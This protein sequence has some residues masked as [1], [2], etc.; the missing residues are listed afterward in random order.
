MTQYYTGYIADNLRYKSRYN[1]MQ[2]HI[3]FVFLFIINPLISIALLAIH[4][5]HQKTKPENLFYLLYILISLYL[6]LIST[7]KVAVSDFINYK[8]Y[9]DSASSLNFFEYMNRFRQEYFFYAA[10]YA[11]NKV[12]FGNFNLYV[13]LVVFVQ[14][15]LIFAAIH[16]YWR[17]SDVSLILFA[18]LIYAIFNRSFFASTHL[19]RQMIAGSIFVYFYITKIVDKKTHWWLIVVAYMIHSS[20]LLIFFISLIPKLDKKL[21]M[22]KGMIVLCIVVV[23]SVFG[24]HIVNFLEG[25]FQAIKM[26]SFQIQRFQNIELTGSGWYDGEAAGSY[27]YWYFVQLLPFII[28]GYFFSKKGPEAHAILNCAVAFLLLQEL[29]IFFNLEYMQLRF[30]RYVYLLIPFI[31]PFLFTRN[32]LY[33]SPPFKFFGMAFIVFWF[34]YRFV[35]GF[36]TGAFSYAPLSEIITNPVFMYFI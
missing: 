20:S 30:Q 26:V 21:N 32:T 19:L 13:V 24:S 22:K 11:A 14:Y 23:L 1:S 6:G 36:M 29:F 28:F 34:A 7:T 4:I 31:Y 35:R 8:A 9:F 25:V 18:V 15:M 12:F 10:T 2:V 16:K 5:G 3:V 33:N 17:K 27:R